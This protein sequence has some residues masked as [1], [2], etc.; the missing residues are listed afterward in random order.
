LSGDAEFSAARLN[1]D[2]GYRFPIENTKVSIMPEVNIG[3]FFVSNSCSYTAP[4]SWVGATCEQT[5]DVE[6]YLFAGVSLGVAF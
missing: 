4:A 2:L 1:I 3:K 5:S 6:G